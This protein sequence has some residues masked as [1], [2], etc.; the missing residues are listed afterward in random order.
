MVLTAMIFGLIHAVI[1]FT[2]PTGAA[3][4]T[5]ANPATA[6]PSDKAFLVSP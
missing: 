3:S 5:A 4:R 2:A 6:R 1:Y